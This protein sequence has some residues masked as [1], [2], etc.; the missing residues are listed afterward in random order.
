MAHCLLEK[1]CASFNYHRN[2][3]ICEINNSTMS[4]DPDSLKERAGN[5]YHEKVEGLEVISVMTMN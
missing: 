1:T 3:G 2:G 5:E 4:R